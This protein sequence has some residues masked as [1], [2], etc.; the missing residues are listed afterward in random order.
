MRP[1]FRTV[2][3]IFKK[4]LVS[5]QRSRETLSSMLLFALITVVVLIFS[6]ELAADVKQQAF[7]A[8][9]WLALCFAGTMGLTRA[10]AVERENQ[11]LDALLLAPVDRTA[12]FLGKFLANWVFTLVVS[13]V[14]VPLAGFF[15]G[16]NP[17]HWQLLGVV[18]LG[19]LGYS[20]AGIL[21]ATLSQKLSS[22][23]LSLPILLF[24]VL[25]PLLMAAIRA[26]QIIITGNAAAELIT[27]VGMLAGFDVLILAVGILL[28]EPLVS[29]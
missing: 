10:W 18:L 15:Y 7:S 16:V 1:L 6:F 3:L 20:L 24:P 28:F 19:T 14:L 2:W 22:R 4:D 17:F 21:I 29:E 12:F 23:E 11:C 5:E 13:L 25:I 27:W 8:T 9:L 26:T